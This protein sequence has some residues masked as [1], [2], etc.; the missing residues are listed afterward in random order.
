MS[1]AQIMPSGGAGGPSW[2]VTDV[3]E[4]TDQDGTGRYSKGKTVTFQ[5]ASGLTG[6]IFV[7]NTSWQ[8]D[9][10]KGMIAQAAAKL[11]AVANLTSGS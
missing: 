2:T 7:P 6:T 8:P 9:T 5:L 1:N 3:S 4:T 11:D 10:V